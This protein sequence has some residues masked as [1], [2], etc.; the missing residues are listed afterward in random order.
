MD[1]QLE[2]LKLIAQR[3]DSAGIAYMVTGSMAMGLFAVPRMTRDIDLVVE[4]ASGDA[5]RIASLFEK[6]C[7]LD[8]DGIRDAVARHGMFNIIHNEWIIKVDFIVRKDNEYRKV[9]FGRRREVEL[10]GALISVVAPEDLI[11]SKLCWA[12]DSESQVQQDDA[13]QL[14][15][16]VASLDWTYLE[17]WADVLAVRELLDLARAI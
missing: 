7:Y 5:E 9:E 14:V 10:S 6:D 16:S 3:L 17:K 2:F 8:L 15:K 13:R 4:F 1:E 11:L 12:R